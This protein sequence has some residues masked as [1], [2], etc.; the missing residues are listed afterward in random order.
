MSEIGGSPVSDICY[1]TSA[2]SAA[3][4]GAEGGRTAAATWR[5]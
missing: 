5:A 3:R 4:N 1:L 2:Y